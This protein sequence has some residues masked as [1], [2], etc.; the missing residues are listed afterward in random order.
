MGYNGNNK[1][2]RQLDY[3]TGEVIGIY[4]SLQEA[5]DDNSIEPVSIRSALKKDGRLKVKKLRFELITE[6]DLKQVKN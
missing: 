1:P 6:D 4:S 3:D 5:A 2:V